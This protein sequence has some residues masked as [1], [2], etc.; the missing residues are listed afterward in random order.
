MDRDATRPLTVEEAKARLRALGR[1]T[2]VFGLLRPGPKEM[3]LLAF[4]GGVLAG[5]A[6]SRQRARIAIA[7]LGLVLH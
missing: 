5:S 3:L 6:P 4:L 2:T 7:I 1:E